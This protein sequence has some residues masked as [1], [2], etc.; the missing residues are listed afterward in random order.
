MYVCAQDR[1][2][3][4]ELV[5]G[6]GPSGPERLL[7][8]V[9]APATGDQKPLHSSEIDTCERTHFALMERSGLIIDRQADNTVLTTPADFHRLF[10]ATGGALYGQASHGWMGPFQRPSATSRLPGLYLAGGSVHPGRACRWR[11][12][13]GRLAAEALMARLD[14]TSRSRR[15]PTSGGTST[16]SATTGSM[17]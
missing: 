15:A 5:E 16:P 8:L 14:S 3:Q 1:N 11:P 9:N 2:D 13:P 6:I 17:R 12:C 4:G 7:C 10:P